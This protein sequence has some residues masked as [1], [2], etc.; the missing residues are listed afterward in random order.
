MYCFI[1]VAY[2]HR[3]GMI[4]TA[5]ACCGSG[6][7]CNICCR[8]PMAA[9]LLLFL[10]SLQLNLSCLA[11]DASTNMWTIGSFRLRSCDCSDC[12]GFAIALVAGALR[13]FGLPGL[14]HCLGCRGFA[15]SWVAGA[16]RFLGLPGLCDCSGCRSFLFVWGKWEPTIFFDPLHG[17]LT[18]NKPKY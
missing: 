18:T 13:L 3:A 4:G 9:L 1:A 6:N 10:V 11:H 8:S 16:L 15:I 2:A 17:S 7:S 14:C 12:Q 5:I